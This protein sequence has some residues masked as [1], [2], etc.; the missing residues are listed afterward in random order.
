MDSSKESVD[1]NVIAEEAADTDN[2]NHVN[3]L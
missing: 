1:Q 3:F 2:Q